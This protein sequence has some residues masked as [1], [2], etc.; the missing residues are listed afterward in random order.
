MNEKKEV[1]LENVP[2]IE[3]DQCDYT[4][5][6][7][8]ENVWKLADKIKLKNNRYLEYS[9]VVFVS[10]Y[11]CVVPLW[12]QKAGKDNGL[13]VWD[14]HV[15]LIYEGRNSSWVFDLDTLLQFPVNFVDYCIQTF[16]T[17]NILKPDFHRLFRVIS[18][19]NYL[20]IFASD[21]RHMKSE[22]GTWIKPPPPWLPISCHN[23][24]HNLPE[25][26]SMTVKTNG[27]PE[28]GTIYNLTDFY[29]RFVKT[30]VESVHLLDKANNSEIDNF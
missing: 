14:Y 26:I 16:K 24:V 10:N 15:F 3:L 25:F 8:E 20:N 12:K 29:Q 6:Y 7:C 28:Y 4:P 2:I 27:R 18:A 19:S 1:D 13:V 5:H 17:D 11:N 23:E 21:R 30:Q 22:D 9:S